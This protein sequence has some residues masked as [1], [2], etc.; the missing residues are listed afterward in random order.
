M[1]L[2]RVFEGLSVITVGGILLANTT[3]YLPWGVWWN[4]L[5]LWPLLLVAAG[6]DLIG[7]GL[8][9]TWLRAASSL[10]VIGGLLYGAVAMP[11][12]APALFRGPLFRLNPMSGDS[13]PYALDADR[14]TRA[15]QGR[16]TISGGLGEIEV[17]STSQKLANVEG[18]APEGATPQLSVDARGDEVDVDISIPEEEGGVWF[19]SSDSRMRV[20][21]DRSLDWDIELKTGMARTQADLSTLGISSLLVEQG[22]SETTVMLGRPLSTGSAVTIKGGMASSVVRLPKSAEARVRVKQG[23]SSTQFPDDGWTE[24]SDGTW[25]TDGYR[26]GSSA[27]EIDVE[28]G[29]AS[30]RFEWR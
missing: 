12:G 10:V 5:M 8:D 19:G 24:Q 26:A 23:L 4:V 2:K 6:V 20:E 14:D 1:E 18:T 15:V 7:K 29:M 11:S 30:V 21:L 27:W 3:G 25:T 17:G 13:V 22:M 9:N 28:Q 16:A